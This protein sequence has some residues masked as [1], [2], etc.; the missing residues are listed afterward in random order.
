MFNVH[1][2]HESYSKPWAKGLVNIYNVKDK[3][4]KSTKFTKSQQFSIETQTDR[5][6]ITDK[7]FKTN[8]ETSTETRGRIK[9]A[10][11]REHNSADIH[12]QSRLMMLCSPQRTKTP[13]P[14][15]IKNTTYTGPPLGGLL[16]H[17]PAIK[18]LCIV[19]PH[20]STVCTKLFLSA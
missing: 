18:S 14:G 20:L 1:I 13:T 9:T 19:E 12:S 7:N 16:R 4:T 8:T 10:A 3:Q 5:L 11:N 6:N 2:I 17:T 15:Q